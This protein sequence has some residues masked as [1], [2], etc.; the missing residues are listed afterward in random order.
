MR[1]AGL[2]RLALALTV[3]AI[4]EIACRS[5]RISPLTFIAPSDMVVETLKL[6]QRADTWMLLGFTLANVAAAITA[7]IGVGLVAA[8][9]VHRRRRLRQALDP[10]LAS[11]YAVPFFVL[12]P[13]FVAILGLNRWPLI[14]IGFVFA[15]PGMFTAMLDGLDGVPRIFFKVAR[16]HRMSPA[17]TALRLTLP[18][19]APAAFTGVK[20]TIAYSFI[21]IIAGE[22][23][24]ADRGLGFAIAD[25]YNRFDMKTM[26]GLMLIV[27]TLVVIVNSSVRMMEQRLRQRWERA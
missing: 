24:L 20:L 5:G 25:A 27:L 14:L 6:F 23:I 10:F 9:L 13:I 17:E 22:F 8:L 26:Y 12:Y 21:G 16:M 1:A 19:V 3:V 4:L 2:A 18:A 15:V 7:S 11:Y